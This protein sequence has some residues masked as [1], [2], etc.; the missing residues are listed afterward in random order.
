LNAQKNHST[1]NSQVAQALAVDVD[2]S[3]PHDTSLDTDD[4]HVLK[5][6]NH[7]LLG[8]FPE[9]LAEVQLLNAAFSADVMTSEGQSSLAAEIE[10]LRSSS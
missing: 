9:S 8:E 1:S 10:R 2:W 4:L 5:A 3:F 7:F 6:E